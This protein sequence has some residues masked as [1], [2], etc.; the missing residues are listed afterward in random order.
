MLIVNLLDD[1]NLT[2][3]AVVPP[4]HAKYFSVT[5]HSQHGEFVI[6]VIINIPC[7]DYIYTKEI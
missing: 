1:N 5:I 6:N 7:S 2:D 4:T 3:C